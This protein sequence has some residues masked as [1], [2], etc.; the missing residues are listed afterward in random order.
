M[1]TDIASNWLVFALLTPA[2][3]ALCGIIDVCMV[4]GGAY[5]NPRDGA[6]ISAAFGALPLV[7][8]LPMIQVSN[9][10]LMGCLIAVIAGGCFYLHTL[11]FFKTLFALND[12]TSVETFNNLSVVFVPV[13]AF[14]LLGER[15]DSPDYIAL[16]LAAVGASVLA[17]GYV[18]HT[19]NSALRFSLLSVL[20]V[21]FTMVAQAQAL[22]LLGY[23]PAL[24]VFSATTLTC[25]LVITFRSR[26]YRNDITNLCKRFGAM[27][28]ITEVFQQLAVLSSLRAIAVGP[29]VS[30]IAVVEC[31]LPLFI[32]VFSAIAALLVRLRPS[33]TI[34]D[35]VNA[36]LREQ[37]AGLPV[38]L[39]ALVF[40][41][42]GIWLAVANNQ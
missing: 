42:S 5:E 8:A 37:L 9:L 32:M 38:K 30:L 25:A 11:Y 33:S 16:F 15:L 23:W 24:A 39:V 34:N 14:L 20:F 41:L 2:L 22:E 19:N 21:S 3:W 35:A 18:I 26:Q 40:I 12:A 29:Y 6:V 10:T 1:L 27:F 36:A 17:I 31:A 28:I 7:V 4:G 13:L